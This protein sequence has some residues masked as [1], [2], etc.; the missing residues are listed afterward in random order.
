MRSTENVPITNLCW[1]NWKIFG[2][3]KS[4]RENRRL[5]LRHGRSCWE[6]RGKIL[7]IGERKGW[8]VA[9]S[10][11]SMFGRPSVKNKKGELR[12]GVRIV[13]SLLSNR[14]GK[15]EI[16]HDLVD[17]TFCGPNTNWHELSKKK[18]QEL[19]TNTW[20]FWF[21]TFIIR[22][23]T[24]NISMWVTRH[25]TVDWDCSKTQTVLG[26][27]RFEIH[28]GKNSVCWSAHG[29][30]SRRS[31][32]L[33]LGFWSIAFFQKRYCNQNGE[34]CCATKPKKENTSIEDYETLTPN[35]ES[36]WTVCLTVL[37]WTPNP[38]QIC[39]SHKPTRRH[40]DE[41]LFHPWWVEPS[42]PIVQHIIRCFLAAIFSPI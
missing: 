19:V 33:G 13:K 4:S 21:L 23:I 3:G 12:K 27:W 8:P 14:P 26:P 6:M 18:G 31:R 16:W 20:L 40:A 34:T 1:S 11:F 29:L 7:R 9:Q 15:V 35:S 5:V 17:P 39:W 28:I 22:V 32:S 10:L 36:R 2:L 41:R 38:N 25:S 42:S 37:I 30:Y 24:D